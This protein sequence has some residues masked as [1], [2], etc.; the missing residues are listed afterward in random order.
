MSTPIKYK[1]ERMFSFLPEHYLVCMIMLLLSYGLIY[2]L[3]STINFPNMYQGTIVL[4][5]LVLINLSIYNIYD[6]SIGSF[7]YNHF[8]QKETIVLIL[9]LIICSISVLFLFCIYYTQK[10]HSIHYFEYLILILFS[11]LSLCVLITAREFISFYFILEFQGV[12]FYLLASFH[13]TAKISILSGIKYFILNSLVSVFLLLGFSILYLYSGLTYFDD[14]TV[15][16]QYIDSIYTYNKHSL[17][18]LFIGIILMSSTLFFKLYVFPFN[19]WV[20]D[21]YE[22]A[23]LSSVIFFSSVP[24]LNIFYVFYIFYISFFQFFDYW[25]GIIV[26][27]SVGSLFIGSL[28]GIYES[29][30]KRIFAY[31]SISTSGLLLL[32]FSIYGQSYTMHIID[33]IV[34]YSLNVLGA[35]S[36][37]A[38]IGY[39]SFY[40]EDSLYLLAGLY[41]RNPILAL[42]LIFFI[43]NLTG[44]PPFFV[45]FSKL[46]YL[47]NLNLYLEGW[48]LLLI[49]LFITV[50]NFVFYLR[51]IKLLTFSTPKNI[52]F[53][54]SNYTLLSIVAVLSFVFSQF[55]LLNLYAD[56]LLVG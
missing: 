50:L 11:V 20:S 46:E 22:G 25:Y 49:V 52:I 16:F 44:I 40:Y 19:F 7:I 14:Y 26:L 21:V 8:F 56:W 10:A 37:F 2:N 17:Y 54:T 39:R 18:V 29:N 12:C 27:S 23:P 15:L 48:F 31:S 1:K 51:F 45:F 33:Y 4:S 30:I 41:I 47:T 42:L 43:F 3:S 13:K 38:N 9:N 32:S 5:M 24:F 6:L 35:F 28:G 53:S 36:I 55:T 34:S